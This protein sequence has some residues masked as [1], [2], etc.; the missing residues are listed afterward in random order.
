MPVWLSTNCRTPVSGTTNRRF[1][2]PLT[3]RCSSKP[4]ALGP[5]RVAGWGVL[6]SCLRTKN[7]HTGQ[8]WVW[9]RYQ[10]KEFNLPVD[11]KLPSVV[12]KL[13][14]IFLKLC[15]RRIFLVE[16][17]KWAHPTV[18]FFKGLKSQIF[19]FSF[20]NYILPKPRTWRSTL[21]RN[22]KNFFWTG[23]KGLLMTPV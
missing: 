15:H 19:C 23:Y 12:P 14:R 20:E 21:I 2:N 17:Q 11:P 18:R 5:G 1:L 4:V 13:R 16:V 7:S 6:I 22:R 8:A 9:P 3:S 10:G